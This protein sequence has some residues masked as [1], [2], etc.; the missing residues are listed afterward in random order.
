MMKKSFGVLVTIIFL[1]V[2][3]SAPADVAEAQP[4]FN[5]RYVI[6]GGSTISTDCT[7]QVPCDLRHAID[8]V[9]VDGDVI[10]VHS[11]TYHSTVMAIDLIFINKSLTLLGSCEFDATTSFQCF[12]EEQSSFLDAETDKR[13]IRVEG[14]T[15]NE[16]VTIEG[17][18]I[19]RGTGVGMVPCLGGCYDGC[20]AGI[21]ATNLGKL[22]LKNNYIWQNKAGSISG[23]GGGLYAED[24]NFLQAI[25]NT[26]IFNQ[27]TETGIGGGGG[28]FVTGSGG[29][30]AVE[31]DQNLFYNNEVSTENS[32]FQTGAGLSVSESNNVQ[33]TDNQF[34]YQN[35]IQ[36]I[37]D[38]KGSALYLSYNTGVSVEGNDFKNGYGGS[39]VYVAGDSD[40]E[41]V[42]ARNQWWNNLGYYN[43]QLQ[44]P[45]NADVVNNFLGRQPLSTLSRG[46]GSTSIYL[47]G[48]AIFGSNDVD[49]LFNTF[50]AT[51]RGVSIGPYSNVT[52]L[53][54]IFTGLTDA[55]TSDIINVT[56]VIDNNLFHNNSVYN[57]PGT[58]AIYED[59]K[60]ADISSGDFHLLPGSGAIDR[61][62]GG[63][64]DIDIDGQSRPVGAGP[65]PFDVGADEFCYPTYLPF[66]S[67]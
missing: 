25:R 38:I 39:A 52:I 44:G 14:V 36:H 19:M 40:T 49:I 31:F 16:V 15:G 3:V 45:V 13:V 5:Y 43:L 58:H 33:V 22:T 42:I 20:G 18:T 34:L 55:I 17:F 10:I 50:A 57:I 53:S 60:L 62:I 46:G 21:H 48:N 63:D 28:A 27:A 12:P 30:N 8:S 26:F 56:R 32:S 7:R 66:I 59:P 35:Y 65:T 9:A 61:S 2:L 1:L 54:N 41:G 51:N 4:R 29:P 6:P 24:V 64:F 37:T 23:V 47:E 11:G 67:K